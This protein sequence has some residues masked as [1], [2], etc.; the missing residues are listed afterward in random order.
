M[1]VGG[2]SI[3]ESSYCDI[4]MFLCLSAVITRMKPPLQS[5][6]DYKLT[7]FF[8]SRHILLFCMICL[9]IVTTV[10]WND[11]CFK[12]VFQR[13]NKNNNKSKITKALSSAYTP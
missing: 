8:L 11:K 12:K 1:T 7:N 10:D 6:A 3:S 9:F 4:V 5:I 13:P 2:K